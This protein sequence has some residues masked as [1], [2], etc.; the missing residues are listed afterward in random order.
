MSNLYR[1]AI[2]SLLVILS[3]AAFAQGDLK[4]KVFDAYNL[5]PLA[6]AD[7]FFA[8][9]TA[10]VTDE[11]GDFTLACS[12]DSLSI[13]FAGYE[14]FQLLIKNCDREL[15]VGLIPSFY[16]LNT[17]TVSASP[18]GN[19]S[20]LREPQSISPLT[21][22]EM[23]RGNNLFLENAL[24]LVTGVR[25]EKRTM[26]GGQRIT[27][28][29]YGNGTNFNG[30]GY[31]AYLNDIPL[32]DAEGTTILDDVDFS[33]LGKLDAIKGPAS[34]LYGT[35]IGG[36]IKMY[37]LRPEPGVTKLTQE[38]IG[39]SYGLLR[40]NTRLESAENQSSI[41]LNYGHQD[42]DSYR[43][44]SASEKDYL[45]FTG[46]FRPND[47]QIFTAYI[48]YNN[49]KEGL[50]GQLDSI[51]FNT[52]QNA[53]E[54]PY[55]AN[56]GHVNIE[57]FRTSLAHEYRFANWLS[58]R[59]SAFYS[60]YTLDQ[61]FAVGQSSNQV[62]NFG[63]RSEFRL[64]FPLGT[65]QINGVVG[66]EFQRTLAFKK[67][68]GLANAV[69]GALRGD[70]E[71]AT[72]QGSAFTEW[73]VRLPANFLL[74]AGASLNYVT[75]DIIDRL[76]N[77][78]N[79]MHA[80]QS[81]T[82]KFDSVVSPRVALSKVFNDKI[83]AYVA[84][85]SGYSP[86]TSGSVVIA[87]IGQVNTDLKPEKGNQLEIG[88]KGNLLD[89][90]LSY[91][92]AWFNL[93]VEDKLVSQA[94]TDDKG[95]V[96]Y[97]FSTNVGKQENQGVEL[98]LSYAIFNDPN[99][100]LS[101]LRPFINYTYSDFTYKNYKS[102]NNDNNK[103]ID[104]SGKDVVG[105][106]PSVLSAGVDIALKWGIYLYTTYQYVDKMPITNDNNH[107][108]ESYGLLSSKLGYR[109]NLGKHFEI[110]VYGGGENLTNEL[111]YNMVFLNANFNGAPP[112]I[113]LPGPYKSTFYGG[114]SLSY[115]F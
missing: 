106:P 90:K 44:N 27:I 59:T 16:N 25:M 39:G 20:I 91:Q 89:G 30:T 36:V 84:Y 111:Y 54:P 50:A 51:Q 114:G 108:A 87:A 74:T 100:P 13:S 93:M 43:V 21:R 86:P 77:S 8:N 109:T 101:L 78:G 66:G 47:R 73:D 70:L 24:N 63:A 82:K 53:A 35:G 12:N 103:T 97:T 72:Q 26:S 61:A 79:P 56:K 42:Y 67:S 83:S 52:K 112:K 11:N 57:S 32:T 81:G 76:T 64:V 5:S 2:A 49:S 29:G 45:T 38:V 58:N 40:T 94:V 105:I 60:G 14:P 22:R 15:S 80:D 18:S 113:Y 68:Y 37:T 46:D 28:R 99:K 23:L 62:Q 41:L 7:V 92:L 102:D 75:Y 95:S 34:S 115:K 71:T 88:T 31:K 10:A 3:T 1:A 98:A 110:N 96:L 17:V 55:L 9:G 19:S 85:S 107:F 6:G 4:G 33:L 48:A 69:L 65:V 104:Y